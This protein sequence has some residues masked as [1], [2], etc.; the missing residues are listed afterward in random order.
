LRHSTEERA[1][2]EKLNFADRAIAI[3]ASAESV[4]LP[5]APRIVLSIGL[6]IVIVGATFAAGSPR[7]EQDLNRST[8]PT[9]SVALAVIVYVPL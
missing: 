9:L 5:G 8:A 4:M 2:L 1:A 6:V 7:F 3:V